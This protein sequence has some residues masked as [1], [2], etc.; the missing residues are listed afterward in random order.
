MLSITQAKQS[1]LLIEIEAMT[2]GSIRLYS[3]LVRWQ[4]AGLSQHRTHVSRRVI[5]DFAAFR[6][7]CAEQKNPPDQLR[8]FVEAGMKLQIPLTDRNALEKLSLASIAN[9][10]HRLVWLLDYRAWKSTEGLDSSGRSELQELAIHE[11]DL[12]LEAL[13]QLQIC[14]PDELKPTGGDA[15]PLHIRRVAV[16]S[17]FRNVVASAF[18]YG[19][20][21]SSDASR[22][23]STLRQCGWSGSVID[24]MAGT[25]FH[26]LLFAN[27]GVRSI[28]YDG[29]ATPAGTTWFPVDGGIDAADAV[30]RGDRDAQSGAL[31][32][33]W[34]PSTDD[35]AAR[36]LNSFCG[37]YVVFLGDDGTWSGCPALRKDLFHSGRWEFLRDE[38]AR[39]WPSCHIKDRLILLRRAN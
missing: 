23:V 25:G 36:A 13:D 20:L 5:E 32:L 16:L 33:S 39:S 19:L 6:R 3:S 2:R 27:A 31:F 4:L 12:L 28:A 21:S 1:S 22:I 18:T 9:C 11:F 26:S 38:A 10:M 15:E 8:N 37:N 24:P 30:S 7:V 34:P 35:A 17:F 29:G 14:P